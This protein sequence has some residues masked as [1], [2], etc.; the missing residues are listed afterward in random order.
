MEQSA[1]PCKNS[2]RK[3]SAFEDED[4]VMTCTWP[5]TDSEYGDSGAETPA[6]KPAALPAPARTPL[7]TPRASA[8]ASPLSGNSF[9]LDLDAVAQTTGY[10]GPQWTPQSYPAMEQHMNARC[11]GQFDASPVAQ[12]WY[13]CAPQQASPINVASADQ[14][15]SF[16]NFTCPAA[17]LAAP[18]MPAPAMPAPAIAPSMPLPSVPAL[19]AA[20]MPAPSMPAPSMQ[21]LVAAAASAAAQERAKDTLAELYGS[22]LPRDCNHVSAAASHHLHQEMQM[23]C[24]PAS[25]PSSIFSTLPSQAAQVQ[26]AE[27]YFQ[28]FGAH[29]PQ[30]GTPS[31]EKSDAMEKSLNGEDGIVQ[32][33]AQRT[34]TT[35]VMIRNLPN[36]L[37]QQALISHLDE[38]G[39]NGLF[40][41]CYAPR[42]FNSSD[43]LGYAFVNFVSEAAAGMLLGAWHR[44]TPFGAKTQPLSVSE[45]TL[46]GFE[47]NMKKWC[48]ARLRRV[49]NPDFRPFVS[50]D[51]ARRVGLSVASDSRNPSKRAAN[52]GRML[53]SASPSGK[54]YSTKTVDLEL[55]KALQAPT[56][57]RASART[58]RA[59]S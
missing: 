20:A 48:G 44:Q 4:D 54:G 2:R 53:A 10:R 12:Q 13:Q 29:M 36:D 35:T 51:A 1:S 42:S 31:K 5:D 21:S 59:T 33:E 8:Q 38:Y 47:A 23:L 52:N 43:N 22:Q 50:E 26:A 58:V 57:A 27:H 28:N 41:F 16:Q 15:A 7:L 56:P 11:M 45:A 6:S 30:M 18:A 24:A 3:E 25:T 9:C 34:P 32:A 37:T 40:D 14:A 55:V 17:S 49:R 39:F 19:P 46:Q